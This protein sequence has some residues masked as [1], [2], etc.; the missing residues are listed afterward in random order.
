MVQGEMDCHGSSKGKEKAIPGIGESSGAAS[1]SSKTFVV[2]RAGQRIELK[3]TIK[4]P[5]S[6]GTKRGQ[7]GWKCGYCATSK[8][9]GGAT[10]LREHLCGIQGNVQ[11][12]LNVPS[13]V[14]DIMLEQV[15]LCKKKE[16]GYKGKSAIY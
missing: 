1:G 10:R 14:K 16:E 8:Q 15:A 6:H 13:N 9:S 3:G 7:V 2:T 5:W 4:D 11:P 12:C